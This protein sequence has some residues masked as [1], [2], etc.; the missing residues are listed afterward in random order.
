MKR[1]FKVPLRLKILDM[2]NTI[3]L[4]ALLL[5][6]TYCKN[7]PKVP[8]ADPSS[9]VRSLPP[10]DESKF[11]ASE[12]FRRIHGLMRKTGGQYAILVSPN[13][14]MYQ[15]ADSTNTLDSLFLKTVGPL[16][17]DAQTVYIDLTGKPGPPSPM[18]GA[19][20]QTFKIDTIMNK[21][22]ENLAAL[23]YPFDFWVY[24]PDWE[25]QISSFEGGIYYINK[26]TNTAWRG[27]WNPPKY[28]GYSWIFDVP[29]YEGLTE[30]MHIV[31]RL[32]KMTDPK[33]GKSYNYTGEITAKGQTFKS[34]AIKGLGQFPTE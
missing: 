25:L 30:E 31:I 26:G 5:G 29:A 17:Y 22:M 16:H 15:L 10:L 27:A 14:E 4:F 28:D 32:E 12:G 6:F 8:I 33:T 7:D 11:P 2:R 34:W 13:H 9:G 19:M 20:F 24:G 1:T 18:T 21:T 3:F 23:E